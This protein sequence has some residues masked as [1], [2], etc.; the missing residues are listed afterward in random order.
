MSGGWLPVMLRA[1]R[2][3]VRLMGKPYLI[4]SAN[5]AEDF[6]K[7]CRADDFS[8]GKYRCMAVFRNRKDQPVLLMNARIATPPVW[9]VQDGSSVFFFRSETEARDFCKK[10][11]YIPARKAQ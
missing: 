11:G 10:R 2:R 9:R 8:N 6:F 4:R 5:A 3:E 7:C 1:I